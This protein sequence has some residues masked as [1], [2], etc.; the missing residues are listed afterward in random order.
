VVVAIPLFRP[1]HRELL[2]I[3][4]VVCVDCPPELATARLVHDR[5]MAEADVTRRMAAQP[6]REARC[7]LADEVLENTGTPDELARAV[8]DLSARLGLP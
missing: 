4:R 3:D 5:G 6:S 1:E 8:S 2:G 7:A